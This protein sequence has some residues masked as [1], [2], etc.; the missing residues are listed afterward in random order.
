MSAQQ[1]RDPLARDPLARVNVLPLTLANVEARFGA[2]VAHVD[3]IE[4][5]EQAPEQAPA[6]GTNYQPI[7]QQMLF[8]LLSA[9]LPGQLF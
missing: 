9:P 5:C 6:H 7:L 4:T 3:G 2:G 8:P 1:R